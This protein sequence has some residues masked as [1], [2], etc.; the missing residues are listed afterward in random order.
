ML[1]IKFYNSPRWFVNID[2]IALSK[3]GVKVLRGSDILLET[4]IYNREKEANMKRNLN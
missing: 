3:G 4:R 2:V 1:P